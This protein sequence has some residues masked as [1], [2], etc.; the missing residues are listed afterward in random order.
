V[1]IEQL[2]EKA[3]DFA[4][5]IGSFYCGNTWVAAETDVIPSTA[6]GSESRE[7]LPI[8]TVLITIIIISIIIFIINDK[9]I[10]IFKCKDMGV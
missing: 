4:G 10:I 9:I 3:E 6:K 7:R 5:K 2:A 8:I 1:D